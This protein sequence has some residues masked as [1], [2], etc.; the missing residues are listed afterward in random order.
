MSIKRGITPL[1]ATVILVGFAVVIVVL[2]MLWSSTYIEDIQEKQ[3]GIAATRLSC[4]TDISIAI[5]DVQ[6]FGNT[7]TITVEN[8]NQAIDN[9]FVVIHGTEDQMTVTVDTAAPAGSIT[10]LSAV[11]D[12]TRVG[13]INDI[14]IIPR[15]KIAGGV[16]ESCSGQ[17]ETYELS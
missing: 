17:H 2:V 1:L 11:Y 7:L 3:G 6:T 9:F 13:Q 16:Y 8:T 4:A 12:Q 15:I 5:T 10:T 14:D